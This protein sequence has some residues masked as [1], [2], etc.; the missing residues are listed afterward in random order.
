MAQSEGFKPRAQQDL[1]S[2]TVAMP[3]TEARWPRG[4]FVAA[5]KAVLADFKLYLA[6]EHIR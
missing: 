1:S 6:S 2:V 5:R 3:N 4:H